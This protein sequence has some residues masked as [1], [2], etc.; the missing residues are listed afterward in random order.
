MAEKDAA[1]EVADVEAEAGP[2][3]VAVVLRWAGTVVVPLAVRGVSVVV[4]ARV[5]GTEFAAAENDAR[6]VG[7]SSSCISVSSSMAPFALESIPVA[8]L[9]MVPPPAGPSRFLLRRDGTTS[10]KPLATSHASRTLATTSNV[11]ACTTRLLIT[12]DPL[13]PTFTMHWKASENRWAASRSKG[14]VLK[15]A[16]LK[17]LRVTE[18]AICTI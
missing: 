10:G 8:E 3:L 2:L 16:A 14:R 6:D 11:P 12:S 18:L 9:P 4:R 17:W 13:T 15:V 1:R 5:L 7:S